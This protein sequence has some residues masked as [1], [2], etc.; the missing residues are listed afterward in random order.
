MAE[1]L[2]AS[3]FISVT[4]AT[5]F[6][7][8]SQNLND[9]KKCSACGKP[10]YR[11]IDDEAL[12]KTYFAI[13]AW[14]AIDEQRTSFREMLD[15]YHARRQMAVAAYGCANGSHID[16]YSFSFRTREVPQ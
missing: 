8:F 6:M 13:P 7:Q 15:T 14:E 12:D 1:I 3:G 4:P 11:V 9:Q 2:I 10:S 5:Q 16:F